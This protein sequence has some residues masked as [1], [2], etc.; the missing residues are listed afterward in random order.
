MKC[1]QLDPSNYSEKTLKTSQNLNN[2]KN[3][4]DL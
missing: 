1:P 3:L 4:R 2:Y